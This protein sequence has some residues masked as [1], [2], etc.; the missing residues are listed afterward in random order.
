MQNTPSLLTRDDT[1]LGVCE[2]L[3]EDLGIPSNLLR[4]GLAGMLFWNPLFAV[5]AYAGL[6]VIVAAARLVSPNPKQKLAEEAP[7]PAA[8]SAPEAEPV[9]LAA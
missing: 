6:G 4:V 8:A 2:G 1:F 7:F 3:G 5:A 9:A